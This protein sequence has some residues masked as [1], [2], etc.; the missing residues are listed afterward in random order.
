[1]TDVVDKFLAKLEDGTPTRILAFGSSNT[2]RYRVGM[3]WLDG[4]DLAIRETRNRTRMHHCINA[5]IGGNTTRDLLGR[6]EHDAAFYKPHLALIT[7]G[8]NDAKPAKGVSAREFAENLRELKKRFD[9]LGTAVVF[10]T[11]YAVAEGADQ[12]AILHFD[13]FHA[14]MQTVRDVAAAAGAG[15]IDHLAR[16]EPWRKKY[17]HLHAGLMLNAWHV[18]ET[19]NKVLALNIARYFKLRLG[20]NDPDAWFAARLCD[21]M[22]S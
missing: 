16:W 2:E 20:L 12:E 11:Y 18:N 5:G 17:P 14:N 7:I 3:H 21:T 10:Q 19:G 15:L 8:A 13:R 9:A 6:F 22:M 1:M 4:F